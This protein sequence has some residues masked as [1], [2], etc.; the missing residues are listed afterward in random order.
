[1]QGAHLDLQIRFLDE[2]LRPSSGQQLVLANHLTGAFDK[3][4][5]NIEGATAEPYRLVALKQD[6]LCRKEPER[7]KRDRVTIHG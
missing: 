1:V 3:S 6:P 2:R 7:A 4:G 5:Q